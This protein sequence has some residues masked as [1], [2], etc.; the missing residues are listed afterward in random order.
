MKEFGI[1][2]FA[3]H[4]VKLSVGGAV[5][6]DHMLEYAAEKIE[7]AA[8]DKIGEYQPQAGPFGAWA[9]LASSTMDDRERKGFP[10]DE[11]L[12]RTG[13]LRDSI[14]HNIGFQEA[15]IGS[16]SPI[17]EYQELGTDKIP[18]RSFLG[19]AAFEEAPKIVEMLGVEMKTYLVGEAVFE[20]KM[21]IR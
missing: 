8:K 15:H 3:E 12:L 1:G 5:L 9:Q 7:K 11:P 19:G 6:T 18:P 17:A 4:L 14:E 13:E 16:N 2:E 10:E 21:K 20:G